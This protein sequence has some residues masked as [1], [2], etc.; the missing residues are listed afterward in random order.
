M[1]LRADI[2]KMMIDVTKTEITEFKKTFIE[3][4]EDAIQTSFEQD[5]M[6]HI[7]LEKMERDK[8]TWDLF[9]APMGL[10]L[11]IDDEDWGD[12]ILRNQEMVDVRETTDMDDVELTVV[13]MVRAYDIEFNIG[14]NNHKRHWELP[15]DL[16]KEIRVTTL[17]VLPSKRDEFVERLTKRLR[18]VLTEELEAKE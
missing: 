14:R 11:R 12:C 8:K 13:K 7:D 18:V 5:Q 3:S 4:L 17:S 2:R 6:M 16:Q 1:S 9:L 15:S 10:W